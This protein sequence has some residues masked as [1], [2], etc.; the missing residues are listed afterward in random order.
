[1]RLLFVITGIGLGHTIREAAIIDE[2]LKQRPDTRIVI[3]GFKNSYRYFKGKYPVLK[4]KGHK[5]PE[6]SFTINRL[7]LLVMNLPYPLWAAQ[8]KRAL[9]KLIEEF[10]PNKIISDLQPVG[11]TMAREFNIPSVAIYNVDLQSLEQFYTQ[12]SFLNKIQSKI[13]FHYV[14]KTYALADTVIIPRIRLQESNG[15]IK[16]VHPIIRALPS[17]FPQA[18]AVMKK[19]KL[20]QPPIL[21]MLGGS[22]FGYRI[23]EKLITIAKKFDE[24]FVIFGYKNF[25]EKNITSFTFKENFLEYL[26][27]AKA[28]IL[29]SGHTALAECVVYKKPSLVFP[30]KNY[31]EHYLNVHELQECILT[32]YIDDTITEKDLESYIRE[33]LLKSKAL[34]K[35]LQHLRFPINGAQEA[36][37]V[38]LKS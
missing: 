2:I 23:A 29:L 17:E 31:I 33:L 30:F 26:K 3:A 34:E 37:K 12:L 28:C 36:A 20:K 1:M 10:R 32:K 5:F 7:K 21:V 6:D 11:I 19:L 16:N 8:D 24:Q 15:K 25:K 13:I 18:S 27:A 4:L 38:I 22:K 9:R 14:R 35:K